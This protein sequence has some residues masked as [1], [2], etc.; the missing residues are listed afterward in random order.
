M[1]IKE[2]S[3]RCSV[4]GGMF[5]GEASA[6]F[7]AANGEEVSLFCSSKYVDK[8][9]SLLTVRLVSVQ[10]DVASVRLPAES[11]NG[12]RFVQVKADQVKER[13]TA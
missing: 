12:S 8:A 13:Q 4:S 6:S 5:P 3:L 7:K 1:E 11:L 9:G 10:G 2:V